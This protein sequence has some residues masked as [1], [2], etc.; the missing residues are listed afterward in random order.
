[1]I[2]VRGGGS[3][4]KRF[5]RVTFTI[6]NRPEIAA[7]AVVGDFNGWSTTADPMVTDG[8]VFT[9]T[10]SL[11]IGVRY[12]FRYLVD[13]MC[14]ENDWAADDYE[15]NDDGGHNSVLDLTGR[16]APHPWE[17]VGGALAAAVG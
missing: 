12:R 6:P 1:M 13:G 3:R 2:T 9:A 10:L 8:D 4:R 5:A 11:P 16:V 7:A 14:W 17:R 15:A